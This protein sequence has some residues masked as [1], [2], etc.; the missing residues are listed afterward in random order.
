M[1]GIFL[2]L[3][4]GSKAVKAAEP[5][6]F[7]CPLENAWQWSYSNKPF[8]ITVQG[9]FLFGVILFVI[10]HSMHSQSNNIYSDYNPLNLHYRIWGN[11]N[12]NKHIRSIKV[13]LGFDFPFICLCDC[14]GLSDST[15]Q[16]NRI[17]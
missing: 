4:N 1:Y 10:I 7:M 5:V 13:S 15:G 9:A 2:L 14:P 17:L 11:K 6:R 12:I 3:C 16:C 8:I